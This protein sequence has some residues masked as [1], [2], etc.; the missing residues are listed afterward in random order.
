MPEL[1]NEIWDLI[2]SHK[3]ASIVQR[4]WLRYSLFGHS[5]KEDW[6]TIRN[7]LKRK[8]LWPTLIKYSMVRREW[9]TEA[10]SWLYSQ[11]VEIIKKEAEEGMWGFESKRIHM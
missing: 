4:Y 3:A 2:Y 6:S 10:E 1:P 5:R 7:H 9:R 8:H 11:D